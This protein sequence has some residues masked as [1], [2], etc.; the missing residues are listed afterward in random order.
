MCPAKA[1][2]RCFRPRE[3][4]PCQGTSCSWMQILRAP[5]GTRSGSIFLSGLADVAVQMA[6]WISLR[7]SVLD[8]PTNKQDFSSDLPVRTWRNG[9]F[10]GTVHFRIV[11][12]RKKKSL[13]QQA[14]C[15]LRRRKG[16]PCPNQGLQPFVFSR[17]RPRWEPFGCQARR[18]RW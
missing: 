5:K 16:R 18:R 6:A 1:G 7:C 17:K 12:L 3:L 4:L 2:N 13:Y 11:N 15:F 9:G 8:R 14:H 10:C